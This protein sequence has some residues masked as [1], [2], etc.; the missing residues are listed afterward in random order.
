M[1]RTVLRFNIEHYRA[2]LAEEKDEGKRETIRRLL[3]EQ[4]TKLA[5]LEDPPE[6]KEG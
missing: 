3:A 1:K 5:A 6:T 4:E 2:L